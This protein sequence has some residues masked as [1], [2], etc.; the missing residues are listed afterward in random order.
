MQIGTLLVSEGAALAPMAGVSDRSMRR[1]CHEMGAAFCV[2]EMMSAKGFLYAPRDCRATRELTARDPGEGIVGLQLFGREPDLMA[3]AAN[4]L[5]DAGFEF[6]DVNMGCPAHKIVANGEGS[7]LMKEPEL[8]V[9]IVR[10]MVRAADRPVTVKIR[11]GWDADSINAVEMARRLEDAGAAMLTVHGRTREQQYLGRADWEII[12]QVKEAVSIPVMGNG[13]VCSAA[14]ERRMRRETGCDGCAVGRAAQGN[15]WIFREIACACR[16]EEYTPPTPRERV[17]T[18]LRHAQLLC[19]LKGERAAP[20]EMRKH[21]AWY[22]QG[23]R[24]C[25]RLRVEIQ[26]VSTMEGMRE[27]LFG[28]LKR[29]EEEETA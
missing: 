1:L 28:Y 8:A 18:A 29:L 4:Q 22:M 13:D 16:G 3:E 25:S 20:L 26:Q 17:E 5:S 2:S 23:M 11:A 21:L 9:R 6:F 10:A 19:E 24:G 12:R 27:L 15:P 14:D 7:A